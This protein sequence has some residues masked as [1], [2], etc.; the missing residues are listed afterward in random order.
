MSN[1]HNITPHQTPA[2]YDYML[3]AMYSWAHEFFASPNT[4]FALSE[5]ANFF[6]P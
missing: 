3:N 1:L 4:A 2:R 5:S 6:K